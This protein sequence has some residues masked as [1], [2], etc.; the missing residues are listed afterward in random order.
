MTVPVAR[1]RFGDRV[2]HGECRGGIVVPLTD[3]H[4]QRLHAIWPDGSVSWL[5]YLEPDQDG[6]TRERCNDCDTEFRTS[7]PG[8]VLCVNCANE[9]P[10]IRPYSGPG[11][12]A[13]AAAR[14][15][16]TQQVVARMP[17]WA[18]IWLRDHHTERVPNVPA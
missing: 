5:D 8:D 12:F 7:I 18:Q 16:Y 6:Y 9:S 15:R 3:E 17:A 10:Q 13:D 11:P 1:F 4:G 2:R 14:R